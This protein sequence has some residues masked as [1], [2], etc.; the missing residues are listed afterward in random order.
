M[1]TAGR[2][3]RWRG[4]TGVTLGVLLACSGCPTSTPKGPDG[5][6]QASTIS[7]ALE[8]GE[9]IYSGG[10]HGDWHESGS[11]VHES[12]SAGP[13]RVH[14]GNSGEWIFTRTGLSGRFDA[15]A[16]RVR[17]PDGEGEFLQV[18][19][20]SGD[21][22]SFPRVKLRPEH[23]T[24]IG[25]GWTQVIVPMAELNPKAGPFDRVTLATF[26]PFGTDLVL[27]DRV[28][29]AKGGSLYIATQGTG[30]GAGP[31]AMVGKPVRTHVQ[32][33]A[34]AAKINPLIYGVSYG[35]K[36]WAKSGVT[37]RR[38]GGNASTRYNWELHVA[39]RAKDW[40]FENHGELHYDD[41]LAE[42]V[43][44]HVQSAVTVPIIG[45]VSK[46]GSSVSFPV[47]AF[48]PQAK[49]DPW[50]AEAGNG[51]SPSGNDL[52]PGPPTRTSIAA[53]P[54]WVKKWVSAI[55]AA[56][57]KNGKRNVYEY[58]LDN[59]PTLWN[60]THRDV[61]PEPIGYDEL[62]DRTVRYGTAIREADP[63]ALIAG[64]AEWGWTGYQFSARDT[65]GQGT[66]ADHRAHGDMW[67]VEWYLQ[68]LRDHEKTTGT[69]VLDVLD[70]HYYPQA[71]NVYAGGNGGTDRSAQLLRLR[72]TRSLWDPTYVDESWI[73]E[74]IRLL[75]RMKEWVERNYP[76]RGIS[77]G[78]WNFGGGQDVTGALATA[79]ALGR[80]AQFG[81]ASAYF[82]TAPGAASP[83]AFG[84]LAYR[85]FDK[86]GGHFLDYYVP[87]T[88]VDHASFFASRSA[89][90]KHLVVVAINL[91][92]DTPLTAD[93]DLASCGAVATSR[94]YLY[95]RDAS[96]FTGS[97]P[98]PGPAVQRL[99]PP[100]SITVF[101]VQLASGEKAAP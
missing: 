17:E 96:E 62:L 11:A 82:W 42:N 56:D 55:R 31:T 97:D 86:R 100:W 33:D 26:R 89:D 91:D 73:K 28:G 74:P 20:G 54:E 71:N 19:L 43:A 59:E 4:T 70:L 46:D 32:C 8:G 29:L 58:I 30:A 66:H 10:D 35:D 50:N 38:W 83:Q 64:P 13:A 36:D 99:L 81:V 72:S 9:I 37:A 92:P 1:I 52:P 14:F 49:T 84:F 57:T 76:G 68:R 60:S 39:N 40:F 85:N 34:G 75:P 24:E 87:T 69:R 51:V 90:G 63:D 95:A 22:R 53:S 77:L 5:A 16:F 45:W 25:D 3:T 94:A 41:Y 61:H 98:A 2:G 7:D 88:T 78:E 15:V 47:S 23:R 12:A 6:S 48:G 44:A 67:L 93:I 79:E 80:F 21:G 27:F 101:D 65:V 18:Y